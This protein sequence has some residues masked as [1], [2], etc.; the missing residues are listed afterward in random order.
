MNSPSVLSA[1][2]PV[3]VCTA[4]DS[5]RSSA[6]RFYYM[7]S[8]RSILMMLGVVL[9]GALIYSATDHWIVSDSHNS[10]FFSLLDS[11]IHVFRMPTFFII[12]GFFSMMS[13]QKYG[14]KVFTQVRLVRIVVPLLSTALIVNTL[15][16]Y[17]RTTV[18]HHEPMSLGHFLTRVLPQLWLSGQW[19]SHLWF[20]LTLL[21]FF[22][23][24]ISLF[25][26][27]GYLPKWTQ[28]RPLVAG[29]RKNCYFLL[30]IPCADL[31]WN[32]A[33]KIAPNIFHGSLCCGLLNLEDF[34][35]FL[36]Y[37]L[38]GLWLFKDKT[39]QDEFHR[40]ARWEWGMLPLAVLVYYLEENAH[41][42]NTES[43]LR[44]YSFG[45]ICALASHICY[46][47]F[48]R[49]MN[50]DSRVFRYL[51]DA[52]YSIY[53]FHHICVVIFG[54][55]L[56]SSTIAISY[57]FLAVEIATFAVTLSLHHFLILRIPVLRF[58]FNG[59]RTARS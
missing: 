10:I 16:L 13:L 58:L 22:A 50:R 28:M 18:L 19:V 35:T 51:S 8:M 59:K 30:L 6:P 4:S 11:V 15:E 14:I 57:K 31:L 53:L 48:Y 38:L 2:E 23:V 33:A 44:I 9:H 36:P 12:A 43:L 47:L 1:V 29:I 37:F 46:V 34:I 3:E 41:G 7:D 54:Y 5:S 25:L 55:L 49:F 45:V 17:F 39:L 42:F 56:L 40:I 32:V 52:S 21:Q 27:G 20:L 26:I 24:G